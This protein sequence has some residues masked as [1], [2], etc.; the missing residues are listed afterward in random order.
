MS[1]DHDTALARAFGFDAAD[2]A[3]NRAGRLSPDQAAGFAAMARMGRR[4]GP[5]MAIVFGVLLVAG[6]A[7]GLA[8]SHTAIT[9]A[10]VA[11]TVGIAAVPGT[12]FLIAY[13]SQRKRLGAWEQ[14][15][16][17]TV[18][19]PARAWSPFDDT[20]RLEVADPARGP[21]R[22]AVLWDQTDV[23]HEG[24]VYRVHHLVPGSG[25]PVILSIETVAD[26][27]TPG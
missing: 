2:L 14:P 13:R 18:E 27:G 6:V 7:A 1:R 16:V 3:A 21:V 9:P 22:F 19:G 8:G 10:L 5:R 25:H 24:V 12:I 15:Q 23:F 11:I 17:R 26:R 4:S 20:Y